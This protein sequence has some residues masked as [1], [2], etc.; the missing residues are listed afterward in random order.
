MEAPAATLQ[1]RW[2][3]AQRTSTIGSPGGRPPGGLSGGPHEMA[4]CRHSNSFVVAPPGASGHHR[5]A[6]N[7]HAVGILARDLEVDTAR[8]LVTGFDDFSGLL[9]DVRGVDLTQ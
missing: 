4:T 3:R 2:L 1:V 9:V 6:V 7:D 8:V 5:I